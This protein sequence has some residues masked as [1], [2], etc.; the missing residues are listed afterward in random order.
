MAKFTPAVKLLHPCHMPAIHF[1]ESINKPGQILLFV[2]FFFKIGEWK[3]ILLNQE[4]KKKKK[5]EQLR[6]I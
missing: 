3:S 4:V 1:N 6:P 5:S 2:F